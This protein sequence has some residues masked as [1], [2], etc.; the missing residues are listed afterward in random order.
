MLFIV[1]SSVLGP[2]LSVAGEYLRDAVPKITL[3]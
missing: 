3:A 1:L 2:D